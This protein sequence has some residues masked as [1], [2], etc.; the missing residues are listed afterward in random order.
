MQPQNKYLPIRAKF[1]PRWLQ[2]FIKNKNEK[3]YDCIQ[4]QPQIKWSYIKCS[5]S[6]VVMRLFGGLYWPVFWCKYLTGFND[7]GTDDNADKE[8]LAV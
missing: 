3:N 2:F 8:S 7:F 6:H 1:P 4:K 5:S